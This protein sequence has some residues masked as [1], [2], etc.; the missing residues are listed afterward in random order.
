[1][2]ALWHLSKV[3]SDSLIR[4]HPDSVSRFSFDMLCNGDRQELSRLTKFF[5]VKADEIKKFFSFVPHFYFDRDRGF[6]SPGNNWEQLLTRNE[7][8]E[9]KAVERGVVSDPLMSCLLMFGAQ[10]PNLTRQIL[11]AYLYPVKTARRRWNA[12]KQLVIDADAG[13]RLRLNR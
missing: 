6:L 12:L 9:I 10:A 2:L 4:K 7:M 3:T 11:D 8:E 5:P 13:V 1:M